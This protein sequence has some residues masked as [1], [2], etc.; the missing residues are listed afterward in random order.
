MKTPI[1]FKAEELYLDCHGIPSQ[2]NIFSLTL[3]TQQIDNSKKFLGKITLSKFDNSMFETLAIVARGGYGKTLFKQVAMFCNEHNLTFT[4]ERDGST[5]SNAISLFEHMLE[6]N[7]HTV[8][9]PEMFNE[10]VWSEEEINPELVAFSLENDGTLAEQITILD[11]SE[12]FEHPAT[13]NDFFTICLEQESSRPIE[14][15]EPM[16]EYNEVQKAIIDGYKADQSLAIIKRNIIESGISETQ[17]ETELAHFDQAAQSILG[18]SAPEDKNHS[19][20]EF[21]CWFVNETQGE[22]LTPFTEKLNTH[23][24]S[25]TKQPESTAFKPQPLKPL[26]L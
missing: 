9:V 13:W 26:A 23:V 1:N 5:R 17:L 14:E 24:E 16:I 8:D 20:R 3:Y 4:S 19:D 7:Y 12:S 10:E 6:N 18:S 22:P 25:A 15:I 11:L 21:Y 2:D